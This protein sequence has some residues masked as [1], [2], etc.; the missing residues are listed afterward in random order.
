MKMRKRYEIDMCNGPIL[1]KM[2][3]F[4]FPLMLSS[5]L[6]LLFNAADIIVVGS[7]CGDNSLA[8]V[9]SNSAL[10][11]LL[12]NVFI[13][14]SIGANVLMAKFYGAG[15]SKSMDETLHSAMLLSLV[16]GIILTVIGEIF[17]RQLLILMRTPPAILDLATVYLRI[18][19][20]GMPAMMIYNFG[21]AIM[22]AVGDTQRPLY[23]LLA[24]GVIN[25]ALNLLL[26]ICFKMDVA[27]VAIATVM[28]QTVSAALVVICMMRD[29]GAIHFEPKR[30]RLKKDKVLG[31][32]RV[33]LP[34]G[35]QGSIFSLSN[36]FIQSSINT[37]GEVV[38]AGNSA[39]ANI[40]G[41]V[42]MG[43]NAFHHATL[44]FTG[45]NMG[46]GRYDRIKRV[47]F[48]GLACVSVTG[49]ALGWL[50]VLFGKPLLGIYTDNPA[51]I[52]AG[53]VR[54]LMI[55]GPY[56]LCGVM[57]V[58]VGSIRGMGYAILPM[59]ISLV[60]ACGLRLVWLATVYQIP[61]FHTT[62]VIYMSYPVTWAITFLADVIC[63]II[64]WQ[65]RK[66]KI[67]AA[68]NG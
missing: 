15:H 47:L 22:R 43:M 28:S 55:C 26:V 40:E 49:L 60:G 45:Q 59:S 25:V 66:R 14:L 19:F 67:A 1:K 44:S 36:V 6:Q 30:M 53:M 20:I 68:K 7:Y 33:G 8:A 42:Y 56:L 62:Q 17:A 34:A 23:F 52:E 65:I 48:T 10:I 16:S 13:G 63:F 61:R 24:A 58:M 29:K 41:F 9:G 3:L 11:N 39:A 51:A 54:L 2:L 35:F 57:D 31:I 4:A 37:F 18:Y 5:M 46:A 64:I 12:T 50:A 38:V 21:S 32:I 27:G